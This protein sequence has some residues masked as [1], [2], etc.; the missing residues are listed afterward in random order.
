MERKTHLERFR[1]D[2]PN[3]SPVKDTD[4]EPL[5]VWANNEGY[6]TLTEFEGQLFHTAH[7][8]DKAKMWQNKTGVI[9]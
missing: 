8:L 2:F 7:D 4:H 6:V 1:I 5:L 3:L 9:I